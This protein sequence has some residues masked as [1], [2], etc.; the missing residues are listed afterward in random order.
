MFQ[1][2]YTSKNNPS[3]SSHSDFDYNSVEDEDEDELSNSYESTRS[4]SNSSYSGQ[5]SASSLNYDSDYS[6]TSDSQ[7]LQEISQFYSIVREVAKQTV[8][9]IALF[10]EELATQ[11]NVQYKQKQSLVQLLMDYLFLNH[12]NKFGRVCKKFNVDVRKKNNQ[13]EFGFGQTQTQTQNAGTPLV[14]QAA[15]NTAATQPNTTTTTTPQGQ[16]AQPAQPAQ[17]Q[18]A[19]PA[20][21]Q[22]AQPAQGQPAQP[23][24][25]QPTQGAAAAT[26][27]QQTGTPATGGA[28]GAGPT[29]IQTG[30]YSDVAASVRRLEQQAQNVLNT[31]AAL[32][33]SGY[34]SSRRRYKNCRKL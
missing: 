15:A 1:L 32:N 17:G 23:A 10:I 13:F 4:N 19:Q 31:A 18:P 5:S 12:S 34:G 28:I 21:G 16:P 9:K 22:P 8:K 25:G 2:T 7:D 27:Q 11:S 24:Q 20:Q 30:S 33:V 14:Q 29:N 26:Q 3:Y 6:T